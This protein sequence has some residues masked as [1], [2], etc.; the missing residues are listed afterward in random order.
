MD[1]EQL[2]S[3]QRPLKDKYREDP[4]SGVIVHK[5]Q[6]TVGDEISFKI[7]SR[8]GIVEAGL[9]PAAGGTG[10]LACSGDLLL[11][12]LIGCAGVTLGSVSTAMGI[13]IRKG[14]IRAEGELDYRGTMAVSK[15]VLVGFRS[16][17]LIFELNCDA[18][19][20][21]LKTL[22]KLTERYCVV[23]QTIAASTEIC[24]EINRVSN[25]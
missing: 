11:E 15:E 21:K 9:H 23:Y 25:L 10:N 7:E 18:D 17:K 2:R 4:G 3:L 19:V 22:I 13:T 6:G 24:S 20:E 8:H 16:I 5:A 12:A 1:A 14:T